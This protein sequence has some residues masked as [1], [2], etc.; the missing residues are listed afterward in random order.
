MRDLVSE[1]ET[2]VTASPSDKR[3]PKTNWDGSEVLHN[4]GSNVRTIFL[5]SIKHGGVQRICEDCGVLLD[6]SS[7]GQNLALMG[8]R[9]TLFLNILSKESGTLLK[10]SKYQLA[11]ASFSPDRRWIAFVVRNGL[12]RT[13]VMASRLNGMT[14][15]PENEWIAV[16]DAETWHDKVEWAPNGNLLYFMSDQDGF[17][18]IWAQRLDPS[19]KKPLGPAS[20]VYHFHEARRSLATLPLGPVEICVAADRLIFNLGE[21]TG[22]IWITDLQG[23]RDSR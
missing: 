5:T 1:T 3:F 9:D 12:A 20:P 4:E 6:W 13:S 7:D 23:Y 16:S 19:A 21:R 10:H 18:C 15:Q 2:A 17:R 14:A 22:N 11:H 8:R